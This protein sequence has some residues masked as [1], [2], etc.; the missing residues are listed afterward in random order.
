MF[1]SFIIAFLLVGVLAGFLSGLLGIGGGVIFVP[2]QV[3][4]FSMLG[5]PKD[6][7]M[8]LAVGTSLAAIMIST[9]S[10][11][12]AQAQK[13]SIWWE[14][15]S[16]M[17]TG[18]ILGGLTGAFLARMMPPKLLEIFFGAFLILLGVYFFFLNAF[19]ENEPHKLPNFIIV[20]PIAISLGTLSSMLG[21]GGGTIAVPILVYLKVPIRKAIGSAVVIS[22]ILSTVGSIAFLFPTMKNSASI[23]PN[24]IGYLFL[25]SFIPMALGA[26]LFAPIGVKVSH[27]LPREL[28]KKIFA[29]IL[30]L[31]G[32]IMILR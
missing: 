12:M 23:Y 2:L 15:I 5:M 32:I 11:A 24:S 29:F 22:C 19:Q 26:A 14:L 9:L 1:T 16:K 28:L 20:N 13:K 31:I 3:L 7:Q 27:Q 30:T 25:P 18:L 17:L 6:I 21:I 8:K 10:A 4:L